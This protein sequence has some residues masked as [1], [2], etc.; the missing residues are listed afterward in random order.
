MRLVQTVLRFGSSGVCHTLV[1]L[2]AML[3]V[4]AMYLALDCALRATLHLLAVSWHECL[5]QSERGD[6]GE[7]ALVTEAGAIRLYCAPFT[8]GSRR[9]MV[10][11]LFLKEGR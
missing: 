6:L 1:Q 4:G 7:S 10:P 5:H 11:P 3:T 2:A 8:S 9:H